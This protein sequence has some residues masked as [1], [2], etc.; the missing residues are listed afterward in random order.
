[1]DITPRQWPTFLKGNIMQGTVLR[2][3]SGWGFIKP[4]DG[5]ADVFVHQNDIKLPGFRTLYEGEV[6]EFM[7]EITEKGH[8]AKEVTILSASPNRERDRLKFERRNNDRANGVD[9][10]QEPRRRE[11]HQPS[12]ETSAQLEELIRVLHRKGVITEQDVRN[13]IG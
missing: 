9:R 12:D 11:D 10:F 1:V 2:F 3:K 8:Q 5:S 6:V 4:N 7:T 13:L